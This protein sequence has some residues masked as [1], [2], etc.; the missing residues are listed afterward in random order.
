MA[1]YQTALYE[2]RYID[3]QF[4]WEYDELIFESRI[5]EEPSKAMMEFDLHEP[6]HPNWFGIM[7]TIKDGE[8]IEYEL[9]EASVYE[10]NEYGDIVG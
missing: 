9:F 2:V 4:G 1:Q 3:A 5:H 7:K 8:V 10:I 6:S